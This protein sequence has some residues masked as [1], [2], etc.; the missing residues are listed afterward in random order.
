MGEDFGCLEAHNGARRA[1]GIPSLRWN[2]TLFKFAQTWANSIRDSECSFDVSP[3]PY[4]EN[5]YM[6]GESEEPTCKAAVG[7]W[8]SEKEFYNHAT[9]S[10]V[11]GEACEQYTQIVWKDTTDVG[12]AKATCADNSAYIWVC[13]YNPPGNYEGQ[14]PY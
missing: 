12:C 9:N 13:E 7:V 11:D 3:Y 2:T 4:G 1:V 14:K 6:T 8:V 5:I 10:C